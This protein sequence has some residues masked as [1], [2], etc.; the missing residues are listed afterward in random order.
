MTSIRRLGLLATLM[1]A[2]PT[3]PA[4]AGPVTLSI[5]E[6]NDFYKMSEDDGRGGFARLAAVVNAE[7]AAGKHVLVVHAGDT[8]SPSLMSG[9]DKG[10]HMVALFNAL[11]LDVF[12]P[13]NHE[14]DF[15]KDIYAKRISEAKFPI[16]AANLRGP[17]GKLLPAHQDHMMVD[18]EGVK[19]GIVGATLEESEQISSP[20]DL[21]FAKTFDTVAAESKTLRAEGADIVIAIAHSTITND[22]KMFNAHIADLFVLG[23]THDLRVE[24]DEK[25]AMIESGEN[26]QSVIVTDLTLDKN[27]KDGKTKFSWH[28]N[29]RIID[30]ASVTPDAAMTAHVKIYEDQLTK[31]LDVP[32]A[33]LDVALDT[34]ESSSRAGETAFGNF[35]ADALRAATGADVAIT[36][37]GG[38]R[39]N[40]TYNAGNELTRKDVLTELPFGNKTVLIKLKGTDILAALE[41]GLSKLP[42]KSGRF[43][44][45]SGMTVEVD[46][47]KPA[48]SRVTS[49]MIGGK[50]VDPAATYTLAT[51]DYMLNGGDG[52]FMFKSADVL[53]DAKA[54]LL[55]ANDVMVL[56]KKQG[57]IMA[58]I[59]GR[60]VMKK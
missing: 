10:E 12:V 39:G 46:P 52:Y 56:A 40:K 4:F 30:T 27:V 1:L 49:L 58:K 48:G 6:V 44:Q 19:V 41:N 13:G 25:S 36:N 34:K 38:L 57:H 3:L 9:F 2:T 14:F 20:G 22:W 43:P 47:A 11:K 26:S 5:V 60:I 33:M 37:G 53:R 17:D 35:V 16:L 55:I 32:V 45:V 59:E 24:Y 42:E 51:N 29:F 15:G 7:R 54:G 18:V 28:P 21:Q 31:E 8:F 23:H 50:A